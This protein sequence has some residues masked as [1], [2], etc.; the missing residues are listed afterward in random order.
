MSEEIQDRYTTLHQ[1]RVKLDQVSRIMEK[2]DIESFYNFNMRVVLT[3]KSFSFLSDLEQFL[4]QCA[5][6][7]E[8]LEQADKR[9]VTTGFAEDERDPDIS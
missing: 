8:E 1:R 4:D 7:R 3:D 5:R 9:L 2:L 6:E